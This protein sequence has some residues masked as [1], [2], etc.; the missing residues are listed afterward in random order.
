MNIKIQPGGQKN[1]TPLGS[2]PRRPLSVIGTKPNTTLAVIN[3][4]PIKTSRTPSNKPQAR[5]PF[6]HEDNQSTNRSS[7]PIALAMEL[8][9]ITAKN[10]PSGIRILRMNCAAI[11]PTRIP[12]AQTIGMPMRNTSAL[13]GT[14]KTNSH[15]SPGECRKPQKVCQQSIR[16]SC[17]GLLKRPA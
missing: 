8:A 1:K 13:V 6:H 15:N 9:R 2:A 14:T 16:I 11:G 7:R 10:I 12:S 17:T 5:N 4:T 3:L